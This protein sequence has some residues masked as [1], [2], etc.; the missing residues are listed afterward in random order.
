MDDT[1]NLI[2]A[3]VLP[4][5]PQEDPK[6]VTAFSQTANNPLGGPSAIHYAQAFDPN[7]PQIESVNQAYQMSQA[8]ALNAPLV[9]ET[10]PHSEN[11][12]EIIG[13]GL[14]LV[15]IYHFLN[16]GKI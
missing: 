12:L 6:D 3:Q 8:K 16:K 10:K 11:W 15:A 9:Y 5:E 13:L 14:T 4:M 7:Y 2:K 1:I